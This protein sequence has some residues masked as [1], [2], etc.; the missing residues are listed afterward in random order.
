MSDL[1]LYELSFKQ[2]L[3][4]KNLTDLFVFVKN[5]K[6]E[7]K[8]LQTCEDSEDVLLYQQGNN[9]KLVNVFVITAD[10]YVYIF[11]SVEVFKDEDGEYLLVS[12]EDNQHSFDFF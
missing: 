10:G 4:I 3:A 11:E 1:K 2:L 6:D 7:V 12:Y 9:Q 8:I 5:A